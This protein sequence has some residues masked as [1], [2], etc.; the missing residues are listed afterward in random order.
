[1]FANVELSSSNKNSVQ[2]ATQLIVEDTVQHHF[3]RKAD[4]SS[5]AEAKCQVCKEIPPFFY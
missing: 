4:N 2:Q 1:M 3:Y 5:S